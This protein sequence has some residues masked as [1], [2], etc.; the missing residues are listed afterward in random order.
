MCL[1]HTGA[2]YYIVRQAAVTTGAAAAA[3][4]VA[5]RDVETFV[6]LP[7]GH[8]P[9]TTRAAAS[10]VFGTLPTV[11][12][13]DALAGAASS[14]VAA[15]GSDITEV[16]FMSGAICELRIALVRRNDVMYREAM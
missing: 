15:A 7:G 10:T 1:V 14:S 3:A 12:F 6:R 4:V 5:A 16:A 2:A 8:K 13:M 11:S 9:A